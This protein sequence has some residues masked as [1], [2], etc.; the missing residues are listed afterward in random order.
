MLPDI[1]Q[2]VQRVLVIQ[3]GDIEDIVLSGPALSTLRQTLPDAAITMMVLPTLSQMALQLPTV[4]QI[5]VYEGTGFTSSNSEP[6]LNLIEQLSRSAF[7]AAII[8]T[9]KG[10]SPYPW[11]YIC[12][13]AG[14]PIRLGQSQEFGGSVLSQS[15]KLKNT[16]TPVNQHLFLLESAGFPVNGGPLCDHYAS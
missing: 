16:D 7:D 6:E 8:F 9:N 12:Y 1:W 5:W 3:L 10:E 14:I 2:N 15:V 13:L 4:E 11:A